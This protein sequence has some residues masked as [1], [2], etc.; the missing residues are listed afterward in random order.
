MKK[1]VVKKIAILKISCAF[2]ILIASFAIINLF[3]ATTTFSNIEEAWDGVEIAT[4]FSGG[5]GTKDNPYQITKGSELAYLKQ[6]VEENNTEELQNKYFILMQDID[7]GGNNWQGIGAVIDN[8]TKT[9]TGYFDGQ[10]Y[11]IKN[12]KI[13]TPTVINNVDYYGFFNIVNNAEIKNINF[14]NAKLKT[15]ATNKSA[16]IGLVASDIKGKSN[17]NNIA[18]QESSLDLSK[19][20]GTQENKIGGVFG[21]VSEEVILENIYNQMDI[22]DMNGNTFGSVFGTLSGK[23]NNIITQPT[24]TNFLSVNISSVNKI[25]KTGVLENSYK[26]TSGNNSLYIVDNTENSIESLLENLNKKI[27]VNYSW[28]LDSLHLKISRAEDL[29][30]MQND[31]TNDI[32]ILFSFG[33]NISIPLHDTGIESDT[34][35][36]N[37]L[38][39][40]YNHYI[41]LNY[42]E[43]SSGSLPTGNNQDLYNDNNLV[44]VYMKYNGTDISD[45]SLTGYVSLEEQQSNIVYYKYYPVE[46]GYV[47]IEL[48][49]NPYAD[50][51]NNKAFNGWLTDYQNAKIFYDAKDYTRHVRIPVTYS[52]GIPNTI[53]ITMYA[54][55]IK[56]SIAIATSSNSWNTVFANLNDAE[57][58]PI[59]E[60]TYEYED[61]SKYYTKENIANAYYPEEAVDSRGKSLNGQYCSY[62]GWMGGCDFYMPSG[63]EY[64]ESKQYYRFTGTTMVQYTPQKLEGKSEFIIPPGASAAGLYHEVTVSKN[65]SIAGLYDSTGNY[66]ESGTCTSSSGCNYYE[67]TQF[68][69]ETGNPNVITEERNLYYLVTRDT[70][71]IVLRNNK[72]SNF[73]TTKPF[74]LTGINNGENYSNSRL[75]ITNSA[76]VI[77]QDAR[78]EWLEI[79]SNFIRTTNADAT[80]GS[81]QSSGGIYANWNNLK[82]GR[83]IKQTTSRVNA[84]TVVAGNGNN[85]GNSSNL[86]KYKLVIESGVYNTTS[87]TNGTRSR[88]VYINGT[89]VYGNDYDRVTGNNDKLDIVFCASGSW[90]DNVYS[91]SQQTG[92]ALHTI[93]K[94]G[95]F[96][97][98]EYDYSTGIYIGGRSG[99]THYAAKEV[100]VEGGDIYN[101]IGG[102]LSST[103]R[104]DIND[105]YINIKGGTIDIVIGGA[106]ASETYGNRIINM[107]SGTVNYGVF[108]GSNGYTGDD[109]GSYK[110][111]L[112]GATLIYVGGNAIVGNDQ[113]I[114]S[115]SSRYGVTSG[116]VFGIGNGN[117][118]STQVGSAN[119]SNII[120]DGNALIKSNVYGG[121]NYGATGL[122][123][124]QN[125]NGTK[126]STTNIKIL[127][128]NIQGSI[129]GGGNNN[130]SGGS[131]T[132]I[133]QDWWGGGTT[134]TTT[135]TSTINIEMLGGTVGYVYGGSRVKGTVYG[136]T[137]VTVL[138]GTINQ[139]VYG[140]GEGGYQNNSSPGTFI[141]KNVNL[142]IGNEKSTP[143][144]TGSVYGGSA[145]GT[146]NG[147]SNNGSA[148]NTYTTNVEIN[149]AIVKKSVFGG[150]KGSARYNPKVYGNITVTV[151]NGNIANVYG[152]NDAA[153][154]PSNSDTV[155][156]N[157]GTIGNAFGG[158]NK[159][160]Q[161]TTNI[162]LQGATITNKLFGGSNESG[163]VESTNV[164]VK[165]GTA[166][167]IYGGNNLGGK[168]TTN[169]IEI[170]GG[171]ITGDIYGGGSQANAESTKLYLGRATINNVYGGGERASATTTESKIENT[172]IANFYG[173]SN[174]SGIVNQ[175][176]T[177]MINGKIG[178]LYGG[179]NAGGT[180]NTANITVDNGTITTVYGGGNKATST[181]ASIKINNGNIDDI[182][183]GGNNAGLETTTINIAKGE[184][185]NVYGGS[186]QAGNITNSSIRVGEESIDIK[187]DVKAAAT[188][189]WQSTTYSTYA[190]INV[191]LKNN[192]SHII[193]NWKLQLDI[194]QS[195]IYSNYSN[196]E[197][198]ENNST[199]TMDATNRY[200]GTNTLTANGGEYTFSFD[201]LSNQDKD[202]FKVT[203]TILTPD[204]S[205]SS[206]TINNIFGGNN[207]GGSTSTS[208]IDVNGGKIGNIYGGGNEASVDIPNVKVKNAN[209]N[210][211]Y[212]GGNMAN[213]NGDTK[214]IVINS[215]I[216]T[217][218]YGGGNYG[219][220]SGNTEVLITS[221][222][223]LGSAYGGGNGAS[224][225]VNRNTKITVEGDTIIGS[226]TSK[227]PHQGC[228]FGGGN[229]AATGTEQ[230]N[231]S[232]ATVNVVGAKIFGNVYGGANT[233]VVYGKTDTNIGTNAVEEKN[234]EEAPIN[235]GGTVFG[236]GEA[237]A[238]GDENYDF[239][240]ISVTGAIDIDIDGKGYLNKKHDFTISGSIFGSG[241]ASSSSGTSDIYI[242]NLGT[243]DNPSENI[244]IQ[245]AN[246]VTIDNTVMELEGTTDRTN[247]YSDI[248][249]SFNRI[250]ELNIKNNTVLLL[251]R[252][253]N[254]LQSLKSTVDVSGNEQ[255]AAVIIDD[256]TK[257]VTKNVDNRIYMLANR[258]LNVTTNEAATEYGEISGMTFFGM[259]QKYGNGSFSYGLYDDGVD[260]G[261]PGDAGDIIIGGSYVLGLHKVNH[262]ITVDGF[263]SNF[264]NDEYTEIST[265][266]INPT[267]PDSNYYMWTIGISAIN[268][269]FTM[270]ASKYSSLGT[271]E[272]SMREFSKGDTIFEVIGFNS[273][274][275]TPGVG[276]IDS[277]NVPKVADS[278]EDANSLLGL[279]MKSETSEWTSYG[280]TKF[281]SE[282]GGNYTGNKSYKTDSQALAPSM[283][284][285]LYHAKNIS[286]NQDLGTVVITMQ[287]LTPKNEIEY[288]V[289]LITITI[290]LTAK[291]YDDG[292]AYDASITYDKKYEMPAATTVHI[293][294][295]SQFTAY[296]DLYAED[297]FEN[298]Y[299][300]K[301]D[302]HHA[303]VT[304][305]ALPVGTQITM[306][307]YSSQDG[308]PEY[309]YY[310]I[311]IEDYNRA[312]QQL[313]TDNEVTYRI[314]K[315][316]KMGSTDPNNT[317]DEKSANERYYDEKKNRT[318]EE[319][320]FIFD[321]KET[322][323]TGNNL[324]KYMRFEL[325]NSE[326]RTVVTVL[327]I[328]QNYMYFNMYD[329]SNMVLKQT[330]NFDNTNIYPNSAR[331]INYETAVTYDQTAN[332]ESIINT[333]YESTS[334]GLNVI[335]FDNSGNQV[336][337][338]MLTGTS[339][340]MDGVEYFAD[341]EG[342]FR[343]KLAGKVSNLR[344]DIYFLTNET[345]PAGKYKMRF[346]LFAS[347]DGLHN[348]GG[349]QETNQDIDVTIVPS[350]NAI[351]TIS[352]DEY[353]VVDGTK[354]VNELGTSEEK[355]QVNVSE[356]LESP[357]LRVSIYKRNIDNKE[358][359]AYTEVDFNQLFNVGLA[360]PSSNGLTAGTAYER[361]ISMNVTSQNNITWPY[362]ENMISGTYRIVLKL[363]DKNQLIDE[364]IEYIIVKK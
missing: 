283:M 113:L 32:P 189:S 194:P 217:N 89:V 161:T 153:G 40:D 213:I 259:Y 39:S 280:T 29:Q 252:N 221:S 212:G 183:G 52:N 256:D 34:V 319:F 281:L 351:K 357:N 81:S 241:N 23:A 332:R 135:V 172:T 146:V 69:D 31:S 28:Q 37:D 103:N 78:I 145:Y 235:I 239:S 19:T 195:T 176:T 87:A 304:D 5:N 196:T 58:K 193:D 321:F 137:N 260:Y 141:E 339:I 8:N 16:I 268:Y 311:T 157:N 316:I 22:I 60:I 181:A 51:P 132:Y 299:G 271:Y 358:T 214:V 61:M 48:I 42:T 156:L 121:G 152:G 342:V 174:V 313:A 73:N 50:R 108:G 191:T 20:I 324:N 199:Y 95:S 123:P 105:T 204:S 211:V 350:G 59:K 26:L 197:I 130:G 41:G 125:K 163:D 307:D 85:T 17:I 168:T 320:L 66:Q 287:A 171:T 104:T 107:T 205:S 71:I 184:I 273:E 175:A 270:T 188:E 180:T 300:R 285:Y 90:G 263:Y 198:K 323:T 222:E 262:D 279:S 340:R 229:A 185:G 11:S 100:I 266:Y 308:I 65:Q 322:T 120:I 274:G 190:T 82:I 289:Q 257:T 115:G 309:Y 236:G 341:S 325:R 75:D 362:T 151:N 310:T 9:F 218:I 251:Q 343:I 361:L 331:H 238:S 348:S 302:N 158:G 86:T 330:V 77:N 170:T 162:Y 276:L 284:F 315:F 96:G 182:Y 275:L 359:T 297:T 18:I 122:V 179:N 277:N 139:D 27:E 223:I 13:E 329:S 303:L 114:A 177:H 227:A 83:G 12:F 255:K 269:S 144:I 186:N 92:I 209:V 317:Y 210:N 247:E 88:T 201:V 282:N 291:N 333:N 353:K 286:L 301:N 314:D 253:A 53:N 64:D 347:S 46:N 349:L 72:N 24:F 76:L 244:S 44:K 231:N 192:T 294:N 10:G 98:N 290:D 295:Q 240:F 57:M 47:D 150:G 116:N 93:V 147:T 216:N 14:H 354:R 233:S 232:T 173:G 178:T 296:Y 126:E 288:D 68:Y 84:T 138:G 355:I 166:G 102:P 237:N 56:A 337:S 143:I 208:I 101:L 43:S 167:N 91:S 202:N 111:T 140:G 7:L 243:R 338:S 250:D 67:L 136:D 220:V 334:M 207:K 160:G 70:N 25:T 36:I 63:P 278:E 127:G 345:L 249:Y 298:I 110:G 327:G 38:D 254:L 149:N 3:T 133:I 219:V 363:Y 187:L 203:P 272:L 225:I 245:R 206:V 246:K 118:R 228:L 306:L 264:I 148:T 55:W 94:S 230:N 99:G 234:L 159:T 169:N 117:S 45:N 356:N 80:P 164:Y 129:Y 165:S 49:D 142:V 336:S 326:D 54:S 106:G 265:Q 154:S 131:A 215:N 305:Y 128:G 2:L 4:S 74:T 33:Q 261:D 344:K 15:V 364:D 248:E 293:T 124:Y 292:N 224:A 346:S 21:Q 62:A 97:T 258:N 335:L 200:S 312:L 267:P 119:S 35:Y 226:A 30:A 6:V 109:S 155:Y 360:L 112:S 1:P 79:Y 328:R 318:I 134:Y 242:A 352:K